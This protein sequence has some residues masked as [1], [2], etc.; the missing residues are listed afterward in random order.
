[1]DKITIQGGRPLTGSVEVGGS[2]ND[3]IAIM[4]GALLVP[5]K[6]T[7]RNVPRIR[8]VYTLIEILRRIG[9]P[10]VF[11]EDGALEIDATQPTTS[12]TPHDLVRQMRASFNVLGALLTRFG[13]ASV[14]MPGG[15]D[16][17]ARPVNFHVKGL[18]QLG[19]RLH[20]EH[21]IYTGAV[22]RFTGANISLEFPSAGA[23]QHL[24]IAACQ[25]R[26]RTMI[27]NCAAEPEIVN[28]GAFLNSCG[29]RI[30]GAG[31]PTI[32]IEGV[33]ELHPTDFTILP[34]RLQ[35]GTYAL[36]AAI[37][38]G[39]VV[40]KN[41]VLEHCRPVLAKMAEA[42]VEVTR[43][44]AGYRVRRA[45]KIYPTDI[46]TMPHPGFPTDMQQ[47]FAALLSLADGV[48]MITET[49]YESRFRYTTELVRM[50]A[51]IRVEDRTAVIHGVNRL[52]G[53]PVTCT[54]LRG[55]AAV[56]VAG[57]AAE[58]ETTID[59]LE[60]LDRGYEGIVPKLRS[61]GAHITRDNADQ[62]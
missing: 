34:D 26:G 59:G 8:D 46:R 16:I 61:L 13:R 45:G 53:A 18:E 24:M 62:E 20:L 51:D 55:G 10:A 3:S 29:A 33:E 5:G 23:T 48:S 6:T 7:L 39:D 36:A 44:D 17:G 42:G 49:V 56:L 31:T 12:E 41:A 54:D 43:V 50:G 60:H 38:G 27:T 40:I 9:V 4:A 21:G 2:K 52:M 15:C 35:A 37:T 32:T 19:C 1:L 11:H 58:G 14:A 30:S 28:L 57:L 25:A 22:R 47:P